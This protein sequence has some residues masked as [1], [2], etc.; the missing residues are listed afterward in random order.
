MNKN[1][2]KV[3]KNLIFL[4]IVYLFL[5]PS[6]NKFLPTIP[7]YE[8]SESEVVKKMVEDRDNNDIDFFKLT[9]EHVGHAFAEHVEETA[10]DLRN[11]IRH[12]TPV[13]LTIKY[14][15]NRP[16]PYQ[17]DES[18]NYI[19]TDTGRTPAMPAGHA[20]QA[21][22]LSK[23]LS[24]KYPEKKNV[25]D[26][27]AKRCDECRVKAGIHYP[28]DGKLSKKLVDIFYFYI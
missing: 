15:I 18:I 1:T 17:I 21:Y 8:N 19:D 3:F 7:V 25:F 28:S 23:V 12:T 24:K 2:K 20:Y 22:Y 6:Y 9:D 16:R 10:D 13:I 11:M 26:G 14:L 27:I 4:L 5:L